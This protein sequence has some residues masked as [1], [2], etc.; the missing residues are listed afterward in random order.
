VAAVTLEC[1]Y[2]GPKRGADR[3]VL[4]AHGAGADM[5]ASTLTSV[6]DALADAKIPSL[7]FNFPYK[8]AG[9]SGPDRPPVLEASVREAIAELARRTKLDPQRFVLGGRSMGG[10]ICSMVA[11]VDGALGLTLLGYPLHPPGKP[12]QLRVDHFSK[13]TM[14]VLFASGTRDAFGTPDELKKHAKKIKG[15]VTFHWIDTADH[16]FKPLKSSGITQPQALDGVAEAVVAFVRSLPT[17]K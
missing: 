9:R 12:E 4:L 5:N 16:G 17:A 11:A 3:A 10:R 6:A 7:R 13:L 8:S 14:P 15:R 1:E 2:Q